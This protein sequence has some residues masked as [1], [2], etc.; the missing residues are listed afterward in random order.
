MRPV[1]VAV[2]GAGSMGASH[3]RVY[4]T[5]KGAELVAVVDADRE[6]AEHVAELYGARAVSHVSDLEGEVEAASVAVPSSVHHEV[7]LELLGLG[8]DCLIEKPIASDLQQGRALVDAA[9]R[10]DRVLLVGH[11]ERFNPAI[12]QLREI[13]QAGPP[14]LAVDVRRMSAVSSRISDVDVVADLMIHDL[15]VVLDLIGEDVVDVVARGST[16][17]GRRG[18]DYV[19]ALVTFANGV[20]ATFTASR[21]TQ[22]QVRELQ[23]TTEERLL[24]V[25]YSAQALLIHRQGRIGSI[26]GNEPDGGRYVLDVGT[27]RVFVRRSEP[28]AAEL[29]HFVAAVRGAVPPRVSGSSALRA[30]ELATQIRD[31]A[32]ASGGL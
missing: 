2:V 31:M 7:G 19:T 8:V 14:V 1:R 22:N 24:T 32:T 15:D 27:E 4:S 26:G 11:I 29:A 25:D 21:V 6:R 30:L 17:N 3:A 10:L 23:V 18:T 16:A 20:L 9:D 28:L 12:E 5:L 13:V